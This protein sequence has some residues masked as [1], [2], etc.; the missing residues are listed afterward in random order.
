LFPNTCEN[1][2]YFPQ[3]NTRF[4]FPLS[5][6]DCHPGSRCFLQALCIHALAF[7]PEDIFSPLILSGDHERRGVTL[8]HRKPF[9]LTSSIPAFLELVHGASL[10]VLHSAHDRPFS[11][12]SSDVLS[13]RTA[14]FEYAEAPDYCFLRDFSF[15]P[16][17][18]LPFLLLTKKY[19]HWALLHRA[20]HH[21]GR[22]LL[23]SLHDIDFP[24]WIL[25]TTRP[26]VKS[27]PCDRADHGPLPTTL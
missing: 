19:L 9:L 11:Y 12:L 2:L 17:S 5:K 8:S 14:S 4:R 16:T 15:S 13:L 7:L 1:P 20:A 23:S 27:P 22:I 21:L 26:E 6:S 10:L 25:R 24:H 18:R 3:L